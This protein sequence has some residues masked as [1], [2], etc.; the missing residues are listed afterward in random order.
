[1]LGSAKIF[2]PEDPD[3]HSNSIKTTLNPDCSVGETAQ[4]GLT[5]A[6]AKQGAFPAIR[7]SLIW[8]QL[9]ELFEEEGMRKVK[10]L[11]KKRSL[12]KGRDELNH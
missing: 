5:A 12:R 3:F 1:M 8:Y 7:S 10:A 2:L 4:S 9:L 6:L 11:R